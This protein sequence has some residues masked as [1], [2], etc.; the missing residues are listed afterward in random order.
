MRTYKYGSQ[1]LEHELNAT[2]SD[3]RWL[4]LR[5]GDVITNL[6]GKHYAAFDGIQDQERQQSRNEEPGE[7]LI[8][9]KS[10]PPP[11][12]ILCC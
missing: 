9:G 8:S 4:G 2:V 3:L 11:H 7:G 10:D 6:S 12:T 5:S 1:R